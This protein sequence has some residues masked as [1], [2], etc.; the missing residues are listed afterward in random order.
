MED[1][2]S[3][4]PSFVCLCIAIDILFLYDCMSAVQ[5]VFLLICGLRKGRL[6]MICVGL[7]VLLETAMLHCDCMVVYGCEM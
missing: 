5:G 4:V 3:V 2:W 6:W 7:Q 1:E